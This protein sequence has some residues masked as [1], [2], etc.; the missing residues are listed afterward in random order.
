MDKLTLPPTPLTPAIE[1]DYAQHR[2]SVSGESYPEDVTSF[3]GP[4]F[5]SLH[6]YLFGAIHTGTHIA[7]E[8]ALTYINSASTRSFQQFLTMLDGA[9]QRGAKVSVKWVVDPEDETMTELGRDLLEDK[10]WL[11]YEIFEKGAPAAI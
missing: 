4:L 1:F 11:S 6:A 7:V 2:L 5:T 10:Q 9:A 3:Y 8:L